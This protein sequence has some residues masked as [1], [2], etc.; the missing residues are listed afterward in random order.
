MTCLDAGQA[1]QTCT[2]IQANLSKKEQKIMTQ[3]TQN[4]TPPMSLSE[5]IAALGK[6]RTT[7]SGLYNTYKEAKGYEDQ[8]RYE[9]E[10]KLKETGLKSVKGADYS[11]VITETPRIVIKH[12]QSVIEWL[13][14]APNI[15]TDQYIGLKATEFQTLAKTMLKGTGE[16]VPGT[17][18]EVRESLSIRANKKP[19][20]KD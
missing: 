9:L 20:S 3:P 18:V 17:E 14:E 19:G 11:A 15:E 16:L 8:L 10:L 1:T 5:L 12:E 7:A 4:P 6:A 13:K 2:A